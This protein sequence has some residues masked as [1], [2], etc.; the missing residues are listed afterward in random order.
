MHCK[1]NDALH[2]LTV[3]SAYLLAFDSPV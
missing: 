3:T 2:A 1:A